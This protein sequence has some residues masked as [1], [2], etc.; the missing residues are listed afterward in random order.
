MYTSNE[1][2]GAC[3]AHEIAQ[4][5]TN[6]HPEEQQNSYKNEEQDDRQGGGR[7]QTHH[8]VYHVELDVFLLKAQIVFQNFNKLG[9][10]LNV[11]VA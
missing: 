3:V 7:K 11:L 6:A 4:P 8:L 1:E 5:E 9:N 10:C 2:E